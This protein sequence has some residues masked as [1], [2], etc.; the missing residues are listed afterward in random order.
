LQ[1]TFKNWCQTGEVLFMIEFFLVERSNYALRVKLIKP[2]GVGHG[3]RNE[4]EAPGLRLR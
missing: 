1:N 3:R 2:N 4:R